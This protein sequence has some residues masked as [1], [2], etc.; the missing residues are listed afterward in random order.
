MTREEAAT[1]LATPGN[2]DLETIT[3]A[4]RVKL[5]EIEDTLHA[6]V[7]GTG[8]VKEVVDHLYDRSGDEALPKLRRAR[9]AMRWL[10]AREERLLRR[11]IAAYNGWQ[12]SDVTQVHVLND[13]EIWFRLKGHQKLLDGAEAVAMA[14]SL[15]FK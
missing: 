9:D 8:F 5:C 1:I 12:L 15:G 7:K 6:A 13:I 11:A 10:A 2:H 3:T 4:L 14:Y